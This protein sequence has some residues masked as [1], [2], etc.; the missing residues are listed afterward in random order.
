VELPAAVRAQDLLN[1]SQEHGVDFLPG[2]Y[3]SPQHGN[4]HALRLSFGGLSPEQIQRGI[5]VIGRVARQQV[6][7]EI[8]TSE[9][10]AALV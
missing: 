3:F 4:T 6:L 8:Q 5:R 2:K 9:P 10:Q 1:Q 7:E